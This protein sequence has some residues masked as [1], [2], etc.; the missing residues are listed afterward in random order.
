MILFIQQNRDTDVENKHM[1]NK[2]GKGRW[3]ESGKWD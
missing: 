3:D 2:G 1:N